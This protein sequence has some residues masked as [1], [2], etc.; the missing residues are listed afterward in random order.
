MNKYL[1]LV[2]F[3]LMSEKVFAHSH[4]SA[5]SLTHSLEHLQMA[6][7]SWMPYLLGSALLLA[8]ISVLRI[9]KNRRW[10]VSRRLK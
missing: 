10:L 5:D 2:T 9:V 1:T 7:Q 8:V 6:Y 4:P 3:L